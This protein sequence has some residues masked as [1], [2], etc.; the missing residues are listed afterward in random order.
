MAREEY[1]KKMDAYELESGALVIMKGLRDVNSYLTEREPWHKKGVEFAE[2]RQ[3]IVRETLEVVYA[4]CLL[5]L[6]FIPMWA[7]EMFRK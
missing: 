5:L 2:E 7:S 4:L 1:R 6:P 3:I